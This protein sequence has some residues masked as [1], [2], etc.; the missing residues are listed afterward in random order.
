[1]IRLSGTIDQRVVKKRQRYDMDCGREGGAAAMPTAA[2]PTADKNADIQMSN[3]SSV[4][5]LVGEFRQ[6]LDTQKLQNNE[7]AS[8]LQEFKNVLNEIKQNLAKSED[9]V[10]FNYYA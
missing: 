9:P 1:M 3:M 4:Q 6:M 7:F 5:Q 10:K 8:V 2:M